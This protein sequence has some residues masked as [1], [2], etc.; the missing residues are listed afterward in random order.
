MLLISLLSTSLAVSEVISRNPSVILGPPGG[1]KGTI[2]KQIV[3]DFHFHHIS[4]G[5]VLRQHVK[6]GTELGLLARS[7]MESGK[8]VPDEVM[9]D[10]VLSK[11]QSIQGDG[12]ILLDGFPRTV[13]QAEA[14]DRRV[15][16]DMALNLVVPV[17]DIVDRISSRW[18]HAASGR[19]YSYSYNPPKVHGKDDVTGE[20]LSQRVD[21]KPVTIR[22]RL[23]AYAERTSP[24]IEHY[25]QKG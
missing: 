8:L 20:P 9:V 4:T 23:A 2:S 14:L 10:L 12:R 16:V 22:T 6:E 15:G 21:D 19:T 17:E 18:V 13:S 3:E 11:M 5:D 1:G 7:F 25:R 24:V